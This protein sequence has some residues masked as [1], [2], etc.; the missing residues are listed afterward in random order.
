MYAFT[1]IN[2]PI[3]IPLAVFYKLWCV[4]FSSAFSFIHFLLPSLIHGLKLC[5]LVA[6]CLEMFFFSSYEFPVW[7]YCALKTQS[8]WFQFF[9]FIIKFLRPKIWSILVYVCM[10]T[11][12]EHVFCSFGVDCS[13]NVNE[14]MLVD[15]SINSCIFLLIFCLV[16]LSIV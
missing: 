13:I 4:V 16:M 9:K 6:K 3:H 1:A 7:F 11:W 10:S 14:I 15:S 2:F 5:C 12:N 8:V